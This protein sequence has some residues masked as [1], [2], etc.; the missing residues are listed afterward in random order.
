[1]SVV[2]VICAANVALLVVDKVALSNVTVLLFN[3]TLLILNV[4]LLVT[5]TGALPI[6]CALVTLN[7]AL[8]I[9]IAPVYPVLVP[10]IITVPAV[11]AKLPA[12]VKLPLNVVVPTL[13]TVKVL[14]LLKLPAPENVMLL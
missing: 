14:P 3:V 1:L 12:P 11:C 8:L 6:P 13:L 2:K 7:N 4:P 10:D 9:L 5:V